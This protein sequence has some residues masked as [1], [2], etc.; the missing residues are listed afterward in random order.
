MIGT[1]L[2]KLYSELQKIDIYL[3]E[4]KSITRESII[5]ISGVSRIKNPFELAEALG[6]KNMVHAA[7]IIDSLF[8]AN[9]YAPTVIAIIFQHFW[10]LLKIRAFAKDNR[11]IINNF[12]KKQ[13]KEKMKIAHTIGIATGVLRKTDPVNK[14]YPVMI[15]SNIIDQAKNFTDNHLNIIF[16]FLR[17]FDIGIKTGRYKATKQSLH[18]LCNSILNGKVIREKEES[19]F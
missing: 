4:K 19:I 1:E 10:R 15:L 9:F 6:K 8:A 14:A 11:A 7:E 2:E 12:Y 5:K 13:Y 17:D 16:T 18:F 3:P